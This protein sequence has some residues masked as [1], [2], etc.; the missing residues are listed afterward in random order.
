MRHGRT[1]NTALAVATALVLA[2]SAANATT[3]LETGAIVDFIVPTTGQYAI[4]AWGAAGGDAQAFGT[5]TLGGL[6]GELGGD[7]NLVAG[8]TLQVLVG[9][10]GASGYYPGGGGGAFVD[11]QTTS[12]LIVAAGGGG[13]A[14]DSSATTN[15][16]VA[17]GG[18]AQ[19]GPSGGAGDSTPAGYGAGGAGGTNGGGGAVGISN[20][21]GGGGGGGD[22]PA[23]AA[24]PDT[25]GT[26][27]RAS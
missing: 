24:A 17:V 22:S 27:A 13:G 26:A 6:G 16:S 21:C 8:H 12:T 5:T 7:F 25:T 1:N 19:A 20:C 18:N 15:G 2:A 23:M 11:D 3:F 10:Q 4:T 9:E 14:N